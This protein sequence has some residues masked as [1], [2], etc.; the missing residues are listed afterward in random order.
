MIH[1]QTDTKVK[2]PALWSQVSNM[3]QSPSKGEQRATVVQLAQR[4]DDALAVAVERT[5]E[6]ADVLTSRHFNDFT[7]AVRDGVVRLRG[8][9]LSSS[10]KKHIEQVV[11]QTAGVLG[12]DCQLVA[13]NDLEGE[14]AQALSVFTS[15]RDNRLFVNARQGIIDLSG[16]ASSVAVRDAAEQCAA[17]VPHVRAV[18][19]HIEAPNVAPEVVE[20]RVVQPRVGQEVMGQDMSLGRVEIVI[21]NPRNRRVSAIVVRGKFPSGAQATRRLSPSN[22]PKQECCVVIPLSAVRHA[23]QYDVLLNITGV[24]AAQLAEF[25]PALFAPPD[26]GWLPP[27][28]YNAAEVI[29]EQP[30]PP[31]A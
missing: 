13:D 26:T 9:V 30:R 22:M 5:L 19:N 15:E 6:K 23:N 16:K 29:L 8:H 1:Q 20:P 21:I 4:S 27:Y 12:V 28:P 2:E 25:N 14:V 24:Q 10:G 3:K 11:G 17:N 18:V 31:A 7:L